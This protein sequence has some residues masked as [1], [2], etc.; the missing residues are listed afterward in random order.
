MSIFDPDPFRNIR[1]MLLPFYVKDGEAAFYSL[2]AAPRI[3]KF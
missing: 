3:L 2:D 1:Q